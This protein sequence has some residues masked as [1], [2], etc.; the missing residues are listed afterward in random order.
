MAENKKES[1]KEI[2]VELL[3]AMQVP[4]ENIEISEDEKY[5]DI[6]MIHTPDEESLIGR[7]GERFS[8]FIHLVKKIVNRGQEESDYRFSVD[9]NNYQRAAIEKLRNKALILAN[10][11]RDFKKDIMLEALSPYE[12][13]IVHDVLA[14]QNNIKTESTGVGKDRRL[15]IKYVAE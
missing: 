3:K 12:R 9:V 14:G 6:F 5:G 7:D 10:Q 15:V 13:L 8:S 11:A 4:L 1:T 2:I